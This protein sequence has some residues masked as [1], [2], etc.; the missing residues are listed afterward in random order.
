MIKYKKRIE[1]QKQ[2][3]AWYIQSD[4]GDR[5]ECFVIDNTKTPWT[6]WWEMQHQSDLRLWQKEIIRDFASKWSD[7]TPYV[8]YKRN[9]GYS[10]PHDICLARSEANKVWLLATEQ[11]FWFM[12]SDYGQ[13]D[14][15]RENSMGSCLDITAR[16]EMGLLRDSLTDNA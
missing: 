13:V 2:N 11:D 7:I 5:Y 8:V 10:Q 16:R 14:F 3:D 12:P 15:D 1:L 9:A 4:R 6:K